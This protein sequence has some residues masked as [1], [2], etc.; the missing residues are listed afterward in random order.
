MLTVRQ[1][2]RS[3]DKET[4]NK[5]F[6]ISDLAEDEYWLLHYAFVEKRM[7]REYAGT[8]YKVSLEKTLRLSYC[9]PRYV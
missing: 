1:Y 3:L 2:L 6:K 7:A 9:K 8:I 5:L 4:L